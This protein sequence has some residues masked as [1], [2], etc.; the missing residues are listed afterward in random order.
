MAHQPIWGSDP[1]RQPV[2]S[3]RRNLSPNGKEEQPEGVTKTRTDNNFSDLT[4]K[5]ASHG[6]RD[7]SADR[8]LEAAL[9]DIAE[10]ARMNTLAT[11]ALVAL[12]RGDELICR[13]VAG[14]SSTR[15]GTRLDTHLG[16]CGDCVRTQR[17][18]FSDDT[19]TD[20]RVEAKASRL[21]GIRSI[22]VFPIIDGTK[23]VGILE[24]FWPRPHAARDPEIAILQSLSGLIVNKLGSVAQTTMPLSTRE[25]FPSAASAERLDRFPEQAT[26]LNR[27]IGPTTNIENGAHSE[28][29][30]A[31]WPWEIEAREKSMSDS[32]HQ[33]HES[34]FQLAVL[35][36]A[37][38]NGSGKRSRDY[39]TSIL[40][41]VVIALA[42]LLGWM[43]G[44][45]GWEM[46]VDKASE[47]TS[48]VTAATQVDE[49]PPPA[50]ASEIVSKNATLENG[51]AVAKANTKTDSPA[52]SENVD[53]STSTRPATSKPV[54]K[55]LSHEVSDGGL[56]V[57]EK[58]KVVF[59]MPP[60]SKSA[61]STTHFAAAT[62][63]PDQTTTADPIAPLRVPSDTAN[64][65]LLQ[66]VE[67]EYPEQAKLEH[68][69]GPVVLGILVGSD[70]LVKG[71]NVVSGDLQLVN[72][73]SDAV[74]Q[75]RFKPYLLNGKA[76]EFET[77][78]TVNFALPD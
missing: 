43:V 75:W 70:G 50:A 57:Y 41:A 72:A 20:T 27:G 24:L 28:Q 5:P 51:K 42:L 6:A 3:K 15:L 76:V 44:R 47:R 14:D 1:Y 17:A 12:F 67:P 59:Q 63:P 2:E 40:T 74:K 8:A 9:N 25:S 37:D 21:A 33:H 61:Q 78:V 11:R 13:A 4:A 71:L 68:I 16:L 32:S 54:P 49:P 18:Q 48:A 19:E 23:L 65:Y 7:P 30:D 26:P 46:A 52:P 36:D 77:R 34:S 10:Q 29:E 60:T 55:A 31:F 38:G 53:A 69:E 58:G 73:A 22:A 35:K 56:V 62:P 66:R 64:G 39:W 45:A